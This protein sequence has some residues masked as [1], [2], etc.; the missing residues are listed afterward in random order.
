[1]KRR[2]V[3]WGE[4]V[5]KTERIRR[6]GFFLSAI[7][8]AFALA[9]I[10]GARSMSDSGIQIS[11][12]VIIAACFCAAFFIFRATWKRKNRMQRERE[13]REALEAL[14]KMKES[15]VNSEWEKR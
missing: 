2:R 1:M 12:K 14:R 7:S 9:L 11:R 8:F 4:E 3:D 10:A 6:K 15:R 5:R 13:D